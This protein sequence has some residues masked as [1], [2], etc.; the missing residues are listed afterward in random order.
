MRYGNE[1]KL[2]K[3]IKMSEE[4]KINVQGFNCGNEIIDD[5][6]KNRSFSDPQTVTF[7][8]IDEDSNSVVCYYSL[9]CSGI[10]ISHGTGGK[11]TIFPAVE[12]KMFAIDEEYQH[13]KY[14]EEDDV[15][16]S[17]ELFWLVIGEIYDFT[18][19]RC[20]SDKII[21]YSVPKAES[22]YTR[23]SFKRFNN[24]FIPSSSL[25]IDGC[26]PMYMDM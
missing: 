26:I 14:S 23:N 12:I 13:I 19:N 21:L 3:P 11:I 15:N 20:G 4:L 2:S 6:L 5:Y 7:I 25:F 8:I 22:F 17:D 18:D 10:V 9:S 24:L 16:L 1:I